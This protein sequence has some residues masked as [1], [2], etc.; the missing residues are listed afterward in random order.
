MLSLLLVVALEATAPAVLGAV[1]GAADPGAASL[2][3]RLIRDGKALF[4]RGKYAQAAALFERANAVNESPEALLNLGRTYERLKDVA[5]AVRA[6]KEY[7]RLAPNGPSARAVTGSTAQLTKGLATQGRQLLIISVHPAGAQV[8]VNTL[9]QGPVPVVVEV[10][11]GEYRVSVRAPDYQSISRVVTVTAARPTEL[12]F[13]LTA[14]APE[15]PVTAPDPKDPG[16]EAGTPDTPLADP[17]PSLT[18]EPITMTMT[19][20]EVVAPPPPRPRGGRTWTWVAA[21]TAVAGAG[22]GV[23]F[24][25]MADG[26]ATELRTKEHTGQG[27]QDLVARGRSYALVANVSYGVA[28]AAAATAVVLFFV[29]GRD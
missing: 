21:G 16:T 22:A 4:K 6:Y 18:P 10:T 5:K 27:A 13:T 1:E 14:K 8:E 15:N 11:P 25:L 24:G 23:T 19:P 9:D 12:I 26:Q 7:L 17:P 2:A 3:S 29:E 20:T 28:A